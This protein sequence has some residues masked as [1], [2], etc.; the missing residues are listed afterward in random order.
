MIDSVMSGGFFI[1]FVIGVAILPA[2]RP[3]ALALDSLRSTSQN[4]TIAA[5]IAITPTIP[6]ITQAC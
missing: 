5:A 1:R 2:T 6:A 3:T 4:T